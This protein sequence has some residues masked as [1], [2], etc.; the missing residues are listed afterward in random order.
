MLEVKYT[1]EFV[2]LLRKLYVSDNG[3]TQHNE[4]K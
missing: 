4:Q 2:Y 1:Y 3:R